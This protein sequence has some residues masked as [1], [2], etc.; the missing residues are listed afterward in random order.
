M[1]HGRSSLSIKD[2]EEVWTLM[3][4]EYPFNLNYYGNFVE[5]WGIIWPNN[6]RKN[7]FLDFLSNFQQATHRDISCHALKFKHRISSLNTRTGWSSLA[8]AQKLTR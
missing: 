8:T 5:F 6:S 7:C 4:M 2:H 3:M 1:A